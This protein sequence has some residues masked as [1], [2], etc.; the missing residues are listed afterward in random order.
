M[1]LATLLRRVRLSPLLNSL[2]VMSGYLLSRLTGLLRDIVISARFG[3]SPDYGAY[4]AAFRVTDLLYMVIIG[5]ALGSSFIPVF[6]QVWERDDSERAWRLASAVMTWALAL[7][8]VASA[9]LWLTAPWVV[10]WLYAGPDIAPATLA[11]ITALTRFFLL[12]PLLL[13]LGG[14]AMAALNAHDRFALP[15]LAPVIYNLGIIGGALFLAPQLGI[16]GLAWGVVIGALGYVLIQLPGL[17]RLGMRLSL[18]FAR[19]MGELRIIAGQMAPRVIG[20]AAAHLS[21]VVT[22]ALTTRLAM[23]A[24]KLAGLNFAYQMMLLPYGI[25]SLSLSTVAFPRLARL[26]NEGRQDELADLI[27]KT[28]SRILFLTVPAAAALIVLALPIT[29][30]LFERNAFDQASLA[31][32][33][34]PL[35]GFAL[36]LPAFAAAE[37]LIR[38]FYAMQHTTVPVLIGLLQVLLNLG[39]GTL[40]LARGGDVGALALAFS[41]AN[42]LEALLLMLMLNQRLPGIWRAPGFRRSLAATGGATLMLFGLLWWFREVSTPYLPMLRAAGSYTWQPDMPLLAGWLAVTTLLGGLA[43]LGA[44]LALGSAESRAIIQRLRSVGALER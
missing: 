6:L 28:L 23:G 39:I 44:S 43:Y 10:T 19:D 17:L 31:F 42:N 11:L 27:R 33:V 29:R 38:S 5:G 16:W 12:S 32:T 26:H 18:T 20:Q 41:I 1:Q 7:L 40:T 9:L 8:A 36:A 2:I 3:T 30:L 14:L 37:I 15:A 25:F 34:A 35:T 13:G 4:I 24:E 21:T 22:A